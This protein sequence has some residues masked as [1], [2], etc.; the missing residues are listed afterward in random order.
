[1]NRIPLRLW[2]RYKR[3]LFICSASIW[4]IDHVSNKFDSITMDYEDTSSKHIIW[5]ADKSSIRKRTEHKLYDCFVT[6]KG[7]VGSGELAP[8]IVSDLIP[9]VSRN[10]Y[11]DHGESSSKTTEIYARCLG[12]IEGTLPPSC[13][14]VADHLLQR[15]FSPHLDID[16]NLT[17]VLQ[18]SKSAIFVTFWL[19]FLQ[20]R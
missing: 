2:I 11:F 19:V 4:K 8:M 5:N 1:M 18:F 17:G 7:D 10:D 6:F 14:P 20:L 12:D 3:T 16:H 15:N 9:P 13:P